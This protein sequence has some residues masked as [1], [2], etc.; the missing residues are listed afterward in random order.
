M[1][2]TA[3]QL[4]TDNSLQQQIKVVQKLSNQLLVAPSPIQQKQASSPAGAKSAATAGGKPSSKQQADLP[5][6]ADLIVHEIFGTDPLSEHVL[7]ALLQVQQQLAAPKAVFMPCK[8]RVIAALALCP[9]L[10]QHVRLADILHASGAGPLSSARAG[11]NTAAAA[12]ETT[13][14]ATAAAGGHS[15]PCHM[16]DWDVSSLLPLQPRKLELQ[17]EDLQ[18]QMLLLTAPQSVLE[19]D[20]Q[21]PIKLS[22]KQAVQLQGLESALLLRKWMQHQQG[23]GRYACSS[24]DSSQSAGST[25]A[26][27]GA[28]SVGAVQQVAAGG[29][30]AGQQ[31]MTEWDRQGLVVV[32]WFEAD[33]GEGG[34]LSTAPG[35]TRLGHWQQSVEF[36]GSG[37]TRELKR[38]AAGG[39]GAASGHEGSFDLQVSW[40]HDRV[41]FAPSD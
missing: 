23:D 19:L 15:L 40:N 33:C 11:T 29:N 26:A 30:A 39:G 9:A 36:V 24:T 3:Q 22:G 4:V 35:K 32:S 8:V 7:P 17:L 14:G 34:W 1:A 38:S 28:N 25:A 13:A 27:A 41:S 6:K 20:F 5:R 37:V 21:Q 18:D 16:P 31:G 10:L 2:A 12:A